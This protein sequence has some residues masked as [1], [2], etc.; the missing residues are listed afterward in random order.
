[1]YN[2][3][4]KDSPLELKGYVFVAHLLGFKGLF[5]C[6]FEKVLSLSKLVGLKLQWL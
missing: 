6:P 2:C 5:F 1:M 4:G 3:S